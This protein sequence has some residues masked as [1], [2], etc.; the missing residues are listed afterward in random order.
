MKLKKI[1]ALLCAVAMLLV[2]VSCGG[3]T[4]QVDENGKTDQTQKAEPKSNSKPDD[5]TTKNNSP[6]GSANYP[7]PGNNESSSITGED[8]T[9][10]TSNSSSGSSTGNGGNYSSGNSSGSGE[11]NSSGNSGSTGSN[12]SGSSGAGSSAT[13]PQPAQ[14]VHYHSYSDYT[15]D[16]TCTEGGYTTHACSCGDSY[17]DSYTSALG[18][19]WEEIYEEHEVE[20]TE[21]QE[22][23]ICNTC[24]MDVTGILLSGGSM[25]D[26][27]NAT[28][29]SSSAYHSE[30]KEVVTGT[31]TERTVVGYKCSRCG[32]T[33]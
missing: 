6:T 22:F 7:T 10:N 18:H 2:L 16:P 17:T 11:S 13:E 26:H 25:K 29:C 15:V 24:G 27:R 30:W 5:S 1:M 28:G 21:M 3:Q 33:K 19:A 14:P 31:T 20:Q 12:G 32:A 8:T 23:E 9:P 4:A